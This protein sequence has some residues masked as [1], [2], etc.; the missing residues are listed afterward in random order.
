[1][2]KSNILSTFYNTCL[3]MQ[4]VA[5]WVKWRQASDILCHKKMNVAEMQMLYWMCGH[6]RR[7]QIRNDDI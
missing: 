5:G 1:M 2:I 6:T 3:H 4:S 7:D